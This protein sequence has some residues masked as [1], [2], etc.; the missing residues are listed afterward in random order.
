MRL[1]INISAS[2]LVAVSTAML[3][4]SC[5]K[6]TKPES[7]DFRHSFIENE[8][9]EA[10]DAYLNNIREYKNS[11]HKL[12]FLTMKGISDK[13]FS[14]SQ[15]LMAMPDSADYICLRVDGELN[16][17]I[18]SEVAEVREKKG[19]K[20]LLLLDYA[21]IHEAWGLLEDERADKGQAPGTKEELIA[22]FKEQTEARLAACNK[23]GLDGLMVT[24]LGNT[25]N[26]YALNS[27]V[28]YMNAI[29]DFHK[30]NPDKMLAFRGTVRNVVDKE[31]LKEFKYLTIVT[32]EDPN[33][34]VMVGRIF[35][36]QVAKDRVIME[37]SVPSADEP[38]QKGLSPIAAANWLIGELD[39]EDFKILGL[40][41]S[42]ASDDYFRKEGAFIN[43][44]K[45]ISIINPVA[46]TE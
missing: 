18:A 32:G 34:S 15:H 27:H 29:K 12:M 35:G 44:R 9:K 31:F 24:F 22:F 14:Q 10:Y 37:L 46:S 5:A 45:A 8:N 25:S 2:L 36:S 19:T 30:A 23:Y 38:E 33:L 1:N 21:P 43:I 20:S 41:V 6:W 28:A 16:E 42:N 7:L 13:P 4:G 39:N 26:E 40:A 3:L 11:E 17:I